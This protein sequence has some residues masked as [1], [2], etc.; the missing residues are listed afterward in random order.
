MSPKRSV[1]FLHTVPLKSQHKPH[2]QP[3]V[4][5]FKRERIHKLHASIINKRLGTI[6]DRLTYEH[7][8]GSFTTRLVIQYKMLS[9]KSPIFHTM[10]LH[11]RGILSRNPYLFGVK[12]PWP[13][14]CDCS[15]SWP[16]RAVAEVAL[17]AGA[18]LR[19]CQ[20][21]RPLRQP[22]PSA[23]PW[24][25]ASSRAVVASGATC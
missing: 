22:R 5:L 19:G 17:K 25:A 11:S 4:K 7:H 14:C 1:K 10:G 21:R 15:I 12:R 6:C 20:A 16:Q 9:P 23:Q 8:A 3:N 2:C 13:R 24:N 18:A